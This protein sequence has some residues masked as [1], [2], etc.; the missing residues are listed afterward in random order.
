MDIICGDEVPTKG[1]NAKS[2]NSNM[3]FILWFMG[4]KERF[5]KSFPNDGMYTKKQIITSGAAPN[6]LLMK[7]LLKKTINL[8]LC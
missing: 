2:I 8:K 5:N 3:N 7:T 6:H 1:T 4:T